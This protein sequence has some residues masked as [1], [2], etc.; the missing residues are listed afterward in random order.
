MQFGLDVLFDF[1]VLAAAGL[2]AAGAGR[3]V[4]VVLM[5][6]FV[7]VFV[8]VLAVALFLLELIGD[9]AGW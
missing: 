6:V 4:L 2:Y 8:G 3:A 5:G 7:G 9:S 1:V